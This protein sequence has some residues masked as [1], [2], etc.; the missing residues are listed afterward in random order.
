MVQCG[1]HPSVPTQFCRITLL[2]LTRRPT[3]RTLF[4]LNLY[5]C[6]TCSEIPFY[7]YSLTNIKKPKSLFG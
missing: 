2:A 5:G 7:I 4:T 1:T 3:L 6:F